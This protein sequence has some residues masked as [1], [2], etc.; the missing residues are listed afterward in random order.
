MKILF[1]DPPGRVK[2]LNIGFAFLAAVL[3][4]ES[5]E[6]KVL[7]FNNRYTENQEKILKKTLDDF[8]PDIVGFTLLSLSYYTC[9]KLIN[10]VKKYHDCTVVV[11]GAQTFIEQEQLLKDNKNIDVVVIGEGEETILE[12]IKALEHNIKFEEVKGIIF[13]KG[14]KN[15]KYRR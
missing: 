3:K 8:K 6:V 15:N 13:K 12:I 4:K 10:V 5:H 11:G 7:D 14:K 1:I 2:G 9:M